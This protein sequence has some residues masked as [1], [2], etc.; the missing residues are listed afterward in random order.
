MLFF[1]LLMLAI[2]V[3]LIVLGIMIF[4]GRTELIHAYHQKRVKDKAAYG[5]DM[6]R[7]L[8]WMAVPV[9][10]AG[11]LGLF[12]AR[13]WPAAVL[14]LGIGASFLHLLRIQKKH[15]GGLF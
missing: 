5:R 1:T 9:I 8:M 12:T 14:I 7:A 6:G 10:L 4:R 13:G 3:L 11:I 15:N 2:A